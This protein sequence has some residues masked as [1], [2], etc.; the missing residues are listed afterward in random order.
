[1]L[2]L[3]KWSAL[4]TALKV[5]C[6]DMAVSCAFYARTHRTLTQMAFL[7]QQ[8]DGATS[9]QLPAA[10]KISV[11]LSCSAMAAQA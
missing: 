9:L 3:Y 11:L 1:M 6:L 5:E 4:E 2:A 7:L 10:V 8:Q